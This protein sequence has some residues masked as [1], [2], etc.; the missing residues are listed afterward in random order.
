VVRKRVFANRFFQRCAG[1]WGWG[2]GIVVLLGVF[3]P[4]R[5]FLAAVVVVLLGGAALSFLQT[6]AARS[7]AY[8]LACQLDEAA[9][10]EDRIPTALHLSDQDPRDAISLR[11]RRDTLEHLTRVDAGS[12]FPYRFPVRANRCA[13]LAVAFAA[14]LAYRIYSDPPKTHLSQLARPWEQVKHLLPAW[15]KD[16]SLPQARKEAYDEHRADD[17]ESLDALLAAAPDSA[18]AARNSFAIPKDSPSDPSNPEDPRAEPGSHPAQL[19]TDSPR[20]LEDTGNRSEHEP[21]KENTPL[22]EVGSVEGGEKIDKPMSVGQRI[23]NAFGSLLAMISDRPPEQRANPAANPV[24]DQWSPESGLAS[25]GHPEKSMQ[26]ASDHPPNSALAGTKGELMDGKMMRI[27]GEASQPGS[28]PGS[29]S[30]RNDNMTG[31]PHPG[32]ADLAKVAQKFVPLRPTRFKGEATVV[33]GLAPFE[34]S[35]KERRVMPGSR[36]VAEGAEQGTVPVQYRAY[37]QRYFDR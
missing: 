22:E 6:W 26:S 14:L 24:N 12:L 18:D 35:V 1:Y 3:V 9:G 20:T 32:D 27:D 21:E 2:L 13:A 28:R 30:S 29:E 33:G 5:I 25:P 19:E 11:Q 31:E 16:E 7:S 17:A 37:I 8:Q 23:K 34:S 10:L 15:T 36:P 4:L